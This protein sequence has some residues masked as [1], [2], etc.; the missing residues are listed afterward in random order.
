MAQPRTEAVGRMPRSF[1]RTLRG[2]L[3]IALYALLIVAVLVVGSL[4]IWSQGEVETGV[5]EMSRLE[6][7][8]VYLHL[9]GQ[10]PAWPCW[11]G[12]V[13]VPLT[14][15]VTVPSHFWRLA[16]RGEF[17]WSEYPLHVASGMTELLR[18]VFHAGA[19]PL[20]TFPVPADWTPELV[21]P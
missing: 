9:M 14:G 6:A 3:R 7:A 1:S 8:R 11:W 12:Y 15:L 10:K 20:C 13:A 2:V 21:A 17:A 5:G 16:S 4:G 19:S 18:E